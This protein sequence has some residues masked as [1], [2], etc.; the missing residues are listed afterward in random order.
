MLRVN[1]RDGRTLSFD[2][3]SQG[4]ASDW[5]ARQA[6]EGFQATITGISMLWEGK[7][8]SLPLPRMYRRISWS[9]NLIRKSD[10]PVGVELSVIADETRALL[11]VYFNGPVST[12]SD[13]HRVGKPRYIPR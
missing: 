12:R 9:A 7:L 11:T 5:L 2:L 13:L 8:H 1:V 10:V 3:L 4:G 6:D